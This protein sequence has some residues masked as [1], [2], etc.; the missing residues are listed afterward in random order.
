MD[1]ST[2][3]FH[4]QKEG[5]SKTFR[6]THLEGQTAARNYALHPGSILR[7]ADESTFP[8]VSPWSRMPYRLA[9]GPNQMDWLSLVRG[10]R[11]RQIFRHDG[12]RGLTCHSQ[13]E[14]PRSAVF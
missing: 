10:G 8:W 4:S 7:T 3:C 14:N 12:P 11:H 2:T 5:R 1:A 6:V 9:R 13:R